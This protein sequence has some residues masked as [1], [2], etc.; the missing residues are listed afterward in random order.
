MD[1]GRQEWMT[2][3]VCMFVCVFCVILFMSHLMMIGDNNKM[4]VSL[5]SAFMGH[6]YEFIFFVCAQSMIP[7]AC[8]YDWRLPPEK[9]QVSACDV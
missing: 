1:A 2:V 3:F 5:F 9:L 4:L 7:S 8:S 6:I